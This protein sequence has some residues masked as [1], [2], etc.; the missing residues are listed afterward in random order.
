MRKSLLW[1]SNY[2]NRSRAQLLFLRVYRRSQQSLNSVE[3][4][5]QQFVEFTDSE[6]EVFELQLLCGEKESIIFRTTLV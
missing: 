3:D 2:T 1:S 4:L 5:D 6:I